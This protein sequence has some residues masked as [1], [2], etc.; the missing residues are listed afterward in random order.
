M[1]FYLKGLNFTVKTIGFRFD[2]V[3]HMLLNTHKGVKYFP[4]FILTRNKHSLR[5]FNSSIKSF[6][7]IKMLFLFLLST[8]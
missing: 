4:N 3:L 7:H 2:L 8:Y 5:D 6:S 1:I